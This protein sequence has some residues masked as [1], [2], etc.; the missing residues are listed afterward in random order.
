MLVV[1]HVE[2]VGQIAA[3]IAVATRACVSHIFFTIFQV[4]SPSPTIG[5]SFLP[6]N[7]LLID[8]PVA[9]GIVIANGED[10]TSEDE[11][12][13]WELLPIWINEGAGVVSPMRFGRPGTFFR[14]CR[15]RALS[16]LSDLYHINGRRGVV[17]F[18]QVY[19]TEIWNAV[20]VTVSGIHE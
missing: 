2:S 10:G 13:G 5:V 15:E 1:A 7:P 20:V 16:D 18:R 12:K 3:D 14:D 9:R 17:W 11:S 19:Q 6:S 8:L 4:D